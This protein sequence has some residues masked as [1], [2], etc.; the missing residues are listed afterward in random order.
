MKIC[1]KPVFTVMI[2]K[3]GACND[4]SCVP[5][6]WCW[7]LQ[8]ATLL[9]LNNVKNNRPVIL[10]ALFTGCSGKMPIHTMWIP[11]SSEAQINQLFVYSFINIIL[12]QIQRKN[13][14][15]SKVKRV[16]IR[17][18]QVRFFSYN[19]CVLCQ[20]G[21]VLFISFPN[22]KTLDLLLLA[23]RERIL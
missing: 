23:K 19:F 10:R 6:G 22:L 8:M 2:Y 7:P 18:G 17:L 15:L 20:R 4:E 11:S 12:G 5:T 1:R 16:V 13:I 14:V 21:A 3:K 9:P